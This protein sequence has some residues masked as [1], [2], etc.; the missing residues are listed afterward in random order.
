MHTFGVDVFCDYFISVTHLDELKEAIIFSKQN[1]LPCLFIGGGSNLLF[2]KNYQGIVIHLALKGISEE[3]ICDQKVHVSAKAGENWHEFVQYCIA[4]NYAGLENLSL[5]PGNVG[6]SPIQNIGAYGVE[7]KDYFHHCEILNLET[8]E[9]EIWDKKSCQ[10]GYRDSI[11]KQEMKGRVIITEVCFELKRQNAEIKTQYGAIS[12]ELA[13]MKISQPTIKELAKAVVAIRQSKLPDPKKIGNAGSFF[14]NPTISAEFFKELHSKFKDMPFYEMGMEYKIPAGWLIE[15]CGW[16]GIC[17]GNV[18]CYDLQSL[19][20]I[21]KT[22]KASG[23]EIYDFSSKIIQSVQAKF[24]I[25]LERE[26]NIIA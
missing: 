10:F 1:L 15:Q 3:I 9:L 13:K 6:T 5:I 26:V 8:L 25:I 16:K 24:G 18:A 11:F 14:K 23:Q 7:I 17:I 21:N 2:T 22:G 4:K 20:I 19:V 12:D